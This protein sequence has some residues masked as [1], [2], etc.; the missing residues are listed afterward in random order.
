MGG[1]HSSAS[2][3]GLGSNLVAPAAATAVGENPAMTTAPAIACLDDPPTSETSPLLS[4]PSNGPRPHNALSIV[5]ISPAKFWTIYLIICVQLFFNAFDSTIM[6]SSH[7]VISSH[8]NASY[9]ASWLTTSFLLTNIAANPLTVALAEPLGRRFLMTLN[10]T[11]VVLATVWCGLADNML[12]LIMA[13]AVCGAGMAGGG[14]VA[15]LMIADLV[16][17]E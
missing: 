11:I 12:S 3:N 16:A 4:S 5:D 7:P 14:I 15:S 17:I 10:G 8:F 1:P 6:S 9:L 13:R 2:G